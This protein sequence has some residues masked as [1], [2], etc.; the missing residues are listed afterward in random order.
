MSEQV[1]VVRAEDD[2]ESV[3][4][5]LRKRRVRQFPVLSG[6]KLVGI[7]TDRDVRSERDPTAK[8]ETVM[9][10]APM[11]TSPETPVLSVI[12]GRSTETPT[13]G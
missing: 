1:E 5:R 2:V 8:V 11:T 3:R 10:P 7:V 6:G 13:G 4:E 9:T 12:T